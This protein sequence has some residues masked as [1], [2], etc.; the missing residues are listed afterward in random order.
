MSQDSIVAEFDATLSAAER[1]LVNLAH[2]FGRDQVAPRAPRFAVERRMPLDLLRAACAAGLGRVELPRESGGLGFR[3][4]AKLRAVEELARYDFGFAFSLVN[5][6]NATVRVAAANPAIAERLLPPMLRGDRI[7]CA[8]YTE[9]G[10]G[11]DLA[12]LETTARKL[13]GGWLLNGS[14]T[15]VSNGASADV[16]VTLAQTQPGAGAGGG[17]LATFIVEADRPG[18]VRGPALDLEAVPAIGL[19]GFRLNDYRLDDAS[20]LDPPGSSF[21]NALAGINGARTYV[22]A[23]CAAMLES[24]IEAALDHA[25]RREAFGQKLAEFQGLRWSLVAAQTDLAALRL[26]T[27]RAAR[28]LESRG[29][30][31]EESARA[32][33]FAGERTLPHIAACIQALGATGL[34][35]E[36]PLMRHLAACKAAA[37]ADGSTEMVTER[38]GKLMIDRA[39]A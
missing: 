16:A 12:N 27:Y 39:K 30:G 24:A 18:F 36:L 38:L 7:G 9:P 14:K 20:L 31:E 17:G 21:R 5:H 23:M 15:W 6:H 13:D 10:H 34:R 8:A 22:A 35:G 1:D 26:L 32:K 4:S 2:D 33:K 28:A 11:S 19:G 3:F 25:Q 37:F 29:G